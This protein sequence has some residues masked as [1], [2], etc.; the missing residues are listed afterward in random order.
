MNCGLTRAICRLD[1]ARIM[2]FLS[3]IFGRS[4]PRDRLHAPATIASWLWG[5]T[6]SGIWMAGWK[7][8]SMAG[9]RRSATALCAVLLRLENDDADKS[10]RQ[11]SVHL[12]ELFVDDMDGQLRQNGVGDLIVGKHIGKMMSALG[13]R[14]GAYRTALTTGD[15]PQLEEALRR[16]LYRDAPVDDAA[17]AV[18]GAAAG[19]GALRT[20]DGVAGGSQSCRVN[21]DAGPHRIF[22]SHRSARIAAPSDRTDRRCWRARCARATGSISCPSDA[23]IATATIVQDAEGIDVSGRI[24]AALVQNCAFP[25]RIFPYPDQLRLPAALPAAGGVFRHAWPLPVMR[26]N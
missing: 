9:S 11:F 5:A 20:A 24:T 1:K 23:L 15:G 8:A 19:R 4:D 22:A 18:I 25:A 21:S 14:L 13:G 26:L 6:R 10:V 16:N 2:S 12:A 17:V 7:T 3:R